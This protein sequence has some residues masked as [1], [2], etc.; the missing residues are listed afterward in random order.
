MKFV[1]MCALL[2]V[3][4]A[5]VGAEEYAVYEVKANFHD[6]EKV[7]IT[8]EIHA[9]VDK[10][11]ELVDAHAAMRLRTFEA[12]NIAKAE[13]DN[14]LAEMRDEIAALQNKSS[15]PVIEH[16]S[17]RRIPEPR[18]VVTVDGVDIEAKKK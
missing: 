16:Q 14:R 6:P 5:G 12:L 15:K 1:L 4:G 11:L 9:P 18:I 2:F 3:A 7:V 13:I 17:T 8:A 10:K